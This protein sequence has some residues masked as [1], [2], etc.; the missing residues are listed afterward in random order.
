MANGGDKAWGLEPPYRRL[1]IEAVQA[2]GLDVQLG[3]AGC[4]YGAKAGGWR[5]GTGSASIVTDDGL[6][7]GA[8]AGVNSYGSVTAGDDRTFWAAPFELDGEFGGLSSAGLTTAPDHWN[9]AKANP[10]LRQNTT[11]AV[12]ATNAIL[13]PGE[14]KRVAIMAQDGLARAVRPAHAP[15]DGDIVF[16]LS[17]AL[18][19]L[20]EPSSMCVARIGALA[21]DVL[22]RAITRG[23]YEAVGWPGADVPTWK[24]GL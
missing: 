24:N 15:F 11:I 23:V 14:A 21:A 17:T 20:D 7:V 13:S 22:A 12:I 2:A 16:A 5:G 10:G 19:P 4:A 9:L 6:V 1:G 8:I 18:R 3:T